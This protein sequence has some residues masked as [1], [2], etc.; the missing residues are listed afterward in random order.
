MIAMG[1]DDEDP[2]DGTTDTQEQQSLNLSS[3]A[4]LREQTNLNLTTPA[5]TETKRNGSP[6]GRKRKPRDG[7]VK[8]NNQLQQ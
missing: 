3:T 7:S 2:F 1:I 4:E 8:A 5:S 6:S